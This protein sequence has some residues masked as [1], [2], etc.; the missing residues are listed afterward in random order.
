MN[1][2]M[3]Q[4]IFDEYE[5]DCNDCQRYWLDQCDGSK[6]NVQKPCSSFLATKKMDIPEKV[7]SIEEK[8]EN[9]RICIITLSIVLALHLITELLNGV[10]Q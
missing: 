1:S 7:K 8:Y 6:V 5:V 2:N 9:I 3:E 10:I 4:K